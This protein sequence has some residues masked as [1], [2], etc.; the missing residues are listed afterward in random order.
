MPDGTRWT[1]DWNANGFLTKVTRPDGR[2]VTF[3]YDP[4]GRRI[5]KQYGRKVTRWVWDGNVPLH[6]WREDLPPVPIGGTTR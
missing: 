4:L 1:Y 3:A 5:R 2:E 6:E